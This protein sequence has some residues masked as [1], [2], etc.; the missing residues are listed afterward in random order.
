MLR[1]IFISPFSAGYFSVFQDIEKIDFIKAY[2]EDI[3]FNTCLYSSLIQTGANFI[4]VFEEN[5]N[6]LNKSEYIKD[7][8]IKIN[9]QNYNEIKSRIN[10]VFSIYESSS[11][12]NKELEEELWN[13]KI[14]LCDLLY[15]V[16]RNSDFIYTGKF[17]SL[18][19]FKD[20]LPNDF[21]LPLITLLSSVESKDIFSPNP[22]SLIS[23]DEVK[24]FD[25]IIQSD[26]YDNYV[27]SHANLRTKQGKSIKNLKLQ[28]EK[29][30]A[31][32]PSL[33]SLYNNLALIVPITKLI[34]PELGEFTE[35][36]KDIST[37]TDTKNT[38]NI[39][40]YKYRDIALDHFG[41]QFNI[42][43]K[44]FEKDLNSWA[45]ES[46]EEGLKM[47]L[48]REKLFE[49]VKADILRKRNLKLSK[50]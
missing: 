48:P 11:K 24:K 4:E 45:L 27:K 23:K 19:R 38:K 22:V 17:P 28:G 8:V 5:S 9:D 3:Q 47:K 6:L 26:I 10:K 2:A 36:I 18:V 41:S 35:V 14:L 13:T 12:G 32:N 29:L 40:I 30:I 25:N 43:M 16:H 49:F 31:S 46:L 7:R 44:R 42:S 21:Y 1:K 34:K 39:I 50:A 15:C 37:S 33:L 20:S